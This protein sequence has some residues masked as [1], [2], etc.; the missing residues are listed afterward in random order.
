MVIG[1][2]ALPATVIFLGLVVGGILL[3]VSWMLQGQPEE[4]D[5]SAEDL[6]HTCYRCRHSN[7]IHARYCA[8]CG[9]PLG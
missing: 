6:T 3:V 9:R 8:W 2:L 1:P 7:P 5:E 4:R